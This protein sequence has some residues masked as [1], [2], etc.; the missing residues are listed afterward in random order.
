M[1]EIFERLRKLRGEK[2]MVFV[3]Q[4]VRSFSELAPVTDDCMRVISADLEI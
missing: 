3:T 4:Y 1:V 2:T